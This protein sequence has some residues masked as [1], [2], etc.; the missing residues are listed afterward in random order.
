MN[1]F[2]A[3]F[4]QCRDEIPAYF[5]KCGQYLPIVENVMKRRKIC[6]RQEL[7]VCCAPN[8]EETYKMIER[9]FHYYLNTIVFSPKVDWDTFVRSYSDYMN[10]VT[11]DYVLNEYTDFLFSYVDSGDFSVTF[12][13]K[14]YDPKVIWKQI[15]TIISED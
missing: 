10:I 13:P 8:S 11:D 5:K 2:N 6:S 7:T 9:I 1:I 14:L 3:E 12:N 4:K 15:N